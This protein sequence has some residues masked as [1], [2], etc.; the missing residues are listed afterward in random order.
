LSNEATLNLLATQL[1]V[2]VASLEQ[3]R[4][5][6]SNTEDPADGITTWKEVYN[7]FNSIIQ[8]VTRVR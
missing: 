2:T 5:F 4:D 3:L 8:G 6:L 7:Q 1:N